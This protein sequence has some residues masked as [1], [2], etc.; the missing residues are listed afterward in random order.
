MGTDAGYMRHMLFYGILPSLFLYL[1]YL[2]AFF[3]MTYS[4]KHTFNNLLLFSMLCGY[5]LLAHYKG[6]FLTGSAMNIKLFSILLVYLVVSKNRF[7]QKDVN[8]KGYL[9]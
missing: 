1:F 4:I 6:D 5:Y 9:R 8:V 3:K 7:S 2:F